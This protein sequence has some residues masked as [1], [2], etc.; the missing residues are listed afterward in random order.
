MGISHGGRGAFTR[1]YINYNQID[2]C[3]V[4]YSEE[5]TKPE[6][7]V[8]NVPLPGGRKKSHA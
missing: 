5:E 3:L 4:I 8:L 1:R 2:L 6:F 7:P